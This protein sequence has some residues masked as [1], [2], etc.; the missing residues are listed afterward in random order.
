MFRF[1]TAAT[2]LLAL[3]AYTAFFGTAEVSG[4]SRT[5]SWNDN[6][7]GGAWTRL[8]RREASA[9]AFVRIA[10]VPPGI[11]QYVDGSISFATGYCYRA[12]AYTTDGMSPYSA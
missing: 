5:V 12:L 9:A 2:C 3:I 4:D 6:S 11:T 8:E 10:D 7:G 1:T